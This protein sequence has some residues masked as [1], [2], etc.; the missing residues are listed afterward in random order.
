MPWVLE[1]WQSS[2]T[3]GRVIGLREPSAPI[4]SSAAF[5]PRGPTLQVSYDVTDVEAESPPGER[6]TVVYGATTSEISE[7]RLYADEGGDAA[8]A[9]V[10]VPREDIRAFAFVAPP[11]ADGVLVGLASDGGELYRRRIRDRR[12]EHAALMQSILESRGSL[13]EL[14]AGEVGGIRWWFFAGRLGEQLHTRVDTTAQE[15]S[16]GGG[17][18]DAGLRDDETLRILHE[19]RGLPEIHVVVGQVKPGIAKVLARTDDGQALAA[20]VVRASELLLHFFV[21][22]ATGSRI[23][24]AIAY[25]EN[26]NAIGRVASHA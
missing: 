25:D 22:A 1:M 6:A 3:G 5:R 15:G 8:A 19:H 11:R 13:R 9:T 20:E 18:G 12:A 2:D 24:E 10:P 26:G 16:G 23:A 4:G 17:L 14:A 7:V 21:A